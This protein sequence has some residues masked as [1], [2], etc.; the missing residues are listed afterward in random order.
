MKTRFSLALRTIVTVAGRTAFG[1]NSLSRF[2][3][4]AMSANSIVDYR[5]EV[6][7]SSVVLV[8]P[9]RSLL[10]RA[11][12]SAISILVMYAATSAPAQTF[13][14][15]YNFGSNPG[16]PEMGAAPGTIVQGRDGNIY[17]TSQLGGSNNAGTIFQIT[18]GGALTVLHNFDNVVSAGPGGLT[19]GT[20]GNF[21]GI[22][23]GSS[24]GL[25]F[26]FIPPS[27]L[28]VLYQFTGNADGSSPIAAPIQALDG[29]LYGTVSDGGRLHKGS[30]YKLTPAG[31]FT[32]LHS[33][34]GKDG[35]DPVAPLV[36]GTDGNFYGTTQFGGTGPGDSG[37]VFKITPT[38]K[39]T[40]L[41]NFDITHGQDSQA[42]LIQGSDG[43]FYGTTSSGGSENSGVIFSITPAGSLT[44][45]HSFNNFNF[46]GCIPVA[47]LV[48]GADGNFYG[49]A[50]SCGTGALGT[51][52]SIT[53]SGTFTVLHNFFSSDG[54][55]PE[56]TLLQDTNGILY[57]DTIT[58]G[59]GALCTCGTFFSL[60]DSLAPFVGLLPAAAKV[61]G[62]LQIFGQGFTGAT[63]VSLNG[64]TA[65]FVVVSDTYM[66]ATIPSGA[67]TG[68]VT[69]TTSGGPLASKQS[70]RILPTLKSFTPTSG[71]V[72]TQVTIK[73]V[74]L[75][76]A[77]QVTFGGVS[78][79]FVVNSDTQ[80]TATVP[81]GAVTGKIGI[82]TLGGTATSGGKFTVTP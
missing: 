36:Q 29:N 45:L 62:Q 39:L 19:L 38:G 3:E 6:S 52:Y 5:R 7:R 49:A 59:S 65:S 9:S 30:V 68:P 25:I 81:T 61:G 28:T 18:P 78:A 16:D 82:T 23:G 4:G 48:Q 71:V 43:N 41:Y 15:M 56:S 76:Q 63:A 14:V 70:F 60:N 20:D 34:N 37:T 32:T 50:A 64:K 58:G 44:V 8:S 40:T 46:D 33:F 2:M 11:L 74:T 10:I 42:P 51:L 12:I 72:G 13:S 27:T 80:V 67:T 79:S 77:T 57:G 35:S 47:G 17:T 73:G 24:A 22:G 31:K 21:Y 26:K 1:G 55:E 66:T 54:E 69:V 53:P 75:T